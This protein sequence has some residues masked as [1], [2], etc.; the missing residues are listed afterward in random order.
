MLFIYYITLTLSVYT[1]F[2]MIYPQ[3]GLSSMYD[4]EFWGTMVNW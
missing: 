4:Y 2:M 1:A 3:I